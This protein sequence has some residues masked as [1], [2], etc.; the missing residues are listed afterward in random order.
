MDRR[1]SLPDSTPVPGGF[2]DTACVTRLTEAA[3]RSQFF[4]AL[5]GEN[6]SARSAVIEEM[7]RNLDWDIRFLHVANPL[8][9][10]LTLERIV[11]QLCGESVFNPDEETAGMIKALTGSADDRQT[12]LIIEQA[13][14]LTH[15]GLLFFQKLPW[16]LPVGA[17][18]PCILFVAAP[19][20]QTLLGSQELGLMRERLDTVLM[21]EAIQPQANQPDAKEPDAKE[22]DTTEKA[23]DLGPL[24]SPDLK[25]EQ[26]TIAPH[27]VAVPVHWEDRPGEDRPGEDRSG[28][29][30]LQDARPL[31]GRRPWRKWAL[32]AFAALMAAAGVSALLNRDK[33]LV[34]ATRSPSADPPVPSLPAT[35]PSP[36]TG[37][38]NT[39]T[40]PSPANTTLVPSLSPALPP[41]AVTVTPAPDATV[42]SAEAVDHPPEK[43]LPPASGSVQDSTTALSLPVQPP[44]GATADPSIE[45]L[46]RE[47]DAFLYNAR[48]GLARLNEA[49]RDLLFQEYVAEQ[50]R[51]SASASPAAVSTS[52]MR[53]PDRHVHIYYRARSTVDTLGAIRLAEKVRG[54][55]GSVETHS[56]ADMRPAPA[57]YYFFPQDEEAARVLAA[58]L[59]MTGVVPVLLDATL[60]YP[61][62]AKGTIEA[63]VL[64][65]G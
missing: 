43:L 3:R 15:E 12:M 25:A 60:S 57:V 51:K 18:L 37:Q 54:L 14:T 1:L 49:Q 44:S 47:F 29:G 42:P 31:I 10:P 13:E 39:V 2:P 59:D 38:E 28:D 20:F 64:K 21:D 19:R 24:L 55:F 30:E 62:P 6:A 61:P 41:A 16:L 58:T 45:R 5:I 11:F 32:L 50:R 8:S 17:A 34:I 33:N 35:T 56:M 26:E 48:P 9:A 22:P 4:L 7:T 46:R 36:A 40:A 65:S 27:S 52:A 53:F 63:W 23:D